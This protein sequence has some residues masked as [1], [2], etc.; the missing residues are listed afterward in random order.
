MREKLLLLVLSLFALPALAQP[1]VH[2]PPPAHPSSPPPARE[3]GPPRGERERVVP[4]VRVNVAPPAPRVE[5][6][7]VAPSPRHIWADGHWAWRGNQHVWLGGGWVAP[8]AP[9]YTWV[10][11]QWVNE[12]GGYVFYEGH[13]SSGYVPQPEV[14]YEPPPPAPEPVYV[15]Q[16]P[17]EPIVEVRPALPF[18]GAIWLP[19]FW[20]WHGHHH[21][22]VGGHYS[23]PRAGY[24]WEGARWEREGGRYRYLPGRW[25][26]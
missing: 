6:R 4:A 8:P 11:A 13:W 25:H 2:A 15:E 18:A 7:G 1:T 24:R 5:V 22:W 20:T 19:G 26:H 23:A 12:G 10:P 9:G 3:V 21:V 17:P 14:V 16:A